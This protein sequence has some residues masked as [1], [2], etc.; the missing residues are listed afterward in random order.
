MLGGRLPKETQDRAE[1]SR[2]GRGQ[3]EV[4]GGF[5]HY[6]RL[7][8]ERRGTEASSSSAQGPP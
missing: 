1:T 8:G 4:G 3:C 5:L 7:W 2:R 6:L